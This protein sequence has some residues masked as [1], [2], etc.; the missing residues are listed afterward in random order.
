MT[1]VGTYVSPAMELIYE[2]GI[3]DF[4]GQ[5]DVLLPSMTVVHPVAGSGDWESPY[6]ALGGNRRGP[7]VLDAHADSPPPLLEAGILQDNP[8]GRLRVM[9]ERGDRVHLLSAGPAIGAARWLPSN[10]AAGVLGAFN[11]YAI[12]YCQA[13]PMRLKVAIQVHGLEPEWS[14]LEIRMLAEEECVSAV[15][16]C[17]PVKIAPEDPRFATIWRAL[18]ETE[19]PVL[20]RAS[21]SAPGW[22][23]RHLL[24]YLMHARVFE[25]YPSVRIAFSETGVGWV[26]GWVPHLDRLLNRSNGDRHVIRGYVEN[27]RILAAV[28]P[29]DEVA[30]VEAAAAELGE[31]ALLWES[32]F[33]LAVNTGTEATSLDDAWRRVLARNGERFLGVSAVAPAAAS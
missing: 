5:W 27:G 29:V 3:P 8:Q 6:L 20:H 19:L 23:P 30:T 10:L 1:D 18:E 22:G 21:F 24:A 2:A 28:S 9:D 7:P 12:D 31:P 26:P 11:Q 25:R 14:A 16:I 4:R 13:D 33:P 32:H 15:S 17:L